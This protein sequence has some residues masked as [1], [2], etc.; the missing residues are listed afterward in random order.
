MIKNSSNYCGGGCLDR[1]TSG[2]ALVSRRLR[3][4]S[5]VD[6]VFVV[7]RSNHCVTASSAVF[8][9]G[10][11]FHIFQWKDEIAA[12]DASVTVS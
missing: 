11:V 5:A 10:H 9:G 1:A 12:T 7:K 8:L 4:P 3:S 6:L 2:V